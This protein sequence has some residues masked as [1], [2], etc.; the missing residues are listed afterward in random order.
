MSNDSFTG[1]VLAYLR[2]P[3]FGPTNKRTP[4]QAVL[5]ALPAFLLMAL[6]LWGS[7][8]GLCWFIAS[9]ISLPVSM[10]IVLMAI[11]AVPSAPLTWV[12]LIRCIEVEAE[13]DR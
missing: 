11:V 10:T 2:I 8:L 7:G 5:H 1:H 6:N 12:I 4:P 3:Q 9:Y 13:L